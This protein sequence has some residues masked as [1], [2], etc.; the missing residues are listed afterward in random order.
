MSRRRAITIYYGVGIFIAVPC[1]IGIG[2][3]VWVWL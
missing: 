1:V 3:I 2:F